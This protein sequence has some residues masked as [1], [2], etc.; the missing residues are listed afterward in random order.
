MIRTYDSGYRGEC[1]SETVEQINSMGWLEKN[2]PYRWPLIFHC[3]NEVTV[4]K[5]KP[6]W[7]NH[8]LMRKKKGVRPGVPDIIDFG[9]IRGAF[10]L[11]RKDRK[12]KGVK[13]TAEQREFLEAVAAS[14][15]FAAI[16]YGAEE[17]KLAYAD[18]INYCIAQQVIKACT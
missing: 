3:P 17:F 18:Y 7:A 15:G 13:T 5:K 1:S 11:K 4:D 10:E 9:A 12:A 6:G 2:Y 16:C 14:G 8:L